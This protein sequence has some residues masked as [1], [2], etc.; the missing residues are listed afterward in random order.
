MKAFLARHP[1]IV[2]ALT[3][4]KG[5]PASSGFDHSTSKGR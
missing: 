3:V 5:Q 1:Q 2:Q 4:I